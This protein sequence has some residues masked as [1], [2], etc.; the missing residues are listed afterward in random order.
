MPMTA[1]G[2]EAIAP[3]NSS[4]AA[5]TAM[6]KPL[7]NIVVLVLTVTSFDRA[8]PTCSPVHGP[9]LLMTDD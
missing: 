5:E 4:S 6:I 8:Y 9:R 2:P 1:A 7:S 3:T